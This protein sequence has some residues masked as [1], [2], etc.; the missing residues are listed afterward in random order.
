VQ[1]KATGEHAVAEGHLGHVPGHHAGHLHESGDAL[2]PHIHVVVGVA[3]HHGFARSA[4]RG[5][6][7][8]NL[9]Q[10]HGEQAKGE[11]VA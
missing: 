11:G 9:V 6:Q 10:G 4:R 2:A 3:H 1:A 8:A 5:M 7:L